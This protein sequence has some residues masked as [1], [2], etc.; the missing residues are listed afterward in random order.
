MNGALIEG[1]KL[2]VRVSGLSSPPSSSAV[3]GSPP[4]IY[5]S[6]LYVTNLPRSMN[7]DKLISL[8][9]PFGQISKVVINVEYSLVYYA[10]VASAITAV[11]N[12]DGYLIEGKRLAVRRSDFCP[13]PTNAAE[14][15]LS[16]SVDKPMKESDMAILLVGSIPPMVTA[17]Q[18]VEL[19]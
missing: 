19:F 11:R 2:T 15:A 1:E 3:Q 7:A 5:K 17:G 14:H 6:R 10:D 16:Q 9:V 8:F 18:L 13:T 4:E 12:M